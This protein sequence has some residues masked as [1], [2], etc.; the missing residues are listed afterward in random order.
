MFFLS[1]YIRRFFDGSAGE[2]SSFAAGKLRYFAGP[3]R[4]NLI[5]MCGKKK[6]L[7]FD[8]PLDEVRRLAATARDCS[9]KKVYYLSLCENAEVIGGVRCLHWQ[10]GLREIMN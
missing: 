4:R 5:Q 1:R 10:Q 9:A 2:K 3:T 8:R 6:H 7:F